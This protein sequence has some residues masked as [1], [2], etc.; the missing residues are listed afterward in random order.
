MSNLIK[1]RCYRNLKKN[2]GSIDAIIE[3]NEIAIREFICNSTSLSTS[4]TDYI[5][6]MSSKHKIKVDDVNF[7]K[8]QHRMAQ[9]YI[10]SVYEQTENFFAEFYREYPDSSNWNKRNETT[11]LEYLLKN[12]DSK[13]QNVIKHIEEWR[14][15]IFAYYKQVR[16]KFMHPYKKDSS[17]AKS[18][19]KINS[20]KEKIIENYRVKNVPNTFEELEF[21]DFILFAKL[22]KDL[23]SR[24]CTYKS[25]SNS[26]VAKMII[27]LSNDEK[28]EVNIKKLNKYKGNLGKYTKSLTGLVEKTY[29]LELTKSQKVAAEIIKLST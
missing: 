7:D 21:D 26:D 1:F 12:I 14:I 3:C 29:G 2:L 8:F 25:Y 6:A 22:V 10:L 23:A 4:P 20:N 17:L 9:L 18:L 5:K 15:D 27:N 19:N 28:S 13:K 11:W 24:L 16:N